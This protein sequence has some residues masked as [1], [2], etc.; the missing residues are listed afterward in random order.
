MCCAVLP[1]GIELARERSSVPGDASNAGTWPTACGGGVG[2]QQTAD[3][4]LLLEHAPSP[5]AP[6]V[7]KREA[8]T[9]GTGDASL[10]SG[11]ASCAGEDGARSESSVQAGWWRTRFDV[12]PHHSLVTDCFPHFHASEADCSDRIQK[13]MP[14]ATEGVE[15]LEGMTEAKLFLRSAQHAQRGGTKDAVALDAVDDCDVGKGRRRRSSSNREVYSTRRRPTVPRPPILHTTIAAAH[16]EASKAST[17]PG[18]SGEGQGAS[19]Q[20][21][22]VPLVSTQGEATSHHTVPATPAFVRRMEQRAAERRL[23]RA[24]LALQMARKTKPVS[25]A[26]QVSRCV[27]ARCRCDFLCGLP[28]DSRAT[29]F[30]EV[31]QL[32]QRDR[33]STNTAA[34]A[35]LY[36]SAVDRLADDYYAYHLARKTVRRMRRAHRCR[37][38]VATV[39]CALA[40]RAEG[41]SDEPPVAQPDASSALKAASLSSALEGL[42]SEE[43]RTRSQHELREKEERSALLKTHR[44][45]KS[46]TILAQNRRVRELYLLRWCF[47]SWAAVWQGSVERRLARHYRHHL[48]EV[49]RQVLSGPL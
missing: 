20:Q 27:E 30:K 39:Q 40:D 38:A 15:D 1:F 14:A 49:A 28:A 24:Q 45:G 29:A 18:G 23:S 33:E 10:S 5:C 47:V 19:A 22:A 48:E 2:C 37:R 7:E 44:H 11:S 34:S 12:D 42:S 9:E 3:T 6:P 26:A 32:L 36:L 31:V 8:S 35:L 21:R 17:V 43:A 46:L 4:T 13:D 25:D 16:R 41:L